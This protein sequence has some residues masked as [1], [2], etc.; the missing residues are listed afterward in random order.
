MVK[1]SSLIFVL[2]FAFLFRLEIFSLRLVG[3]IFFIFIGVVL[4]V[5]SETQFVL[6]GFL[7]ALTASASGGLR[8]SLTQMLL[9]SRKIGMSH[10]VAALFWLAPVMFVTLACISAVVDGWGQVFRSHF[11]DG[12]RASLVTAFY[13]VIP[14]IVAFCMVVSEF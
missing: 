12:W 9:K 8:W 6:S 1:S 13:L 4:M 10:P 7:L 2:L 5:A 11:F 14:G 3:V